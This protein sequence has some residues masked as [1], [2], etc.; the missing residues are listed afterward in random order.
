MSRIRKNPELPEAE[1]ASESDKPARLSRRQVLAGGASI[2]V[3]G[4]AGAM[5]ARAQYTG[6]MEDGL[7]V[8]F[9]LP[10]GALNYLDRNQYINNMEIISYVEGPQISSGEP[11]MTMWARGSRRLIASSN[12]WLDITNP[13][14]PEIMDLG[15]R[16]QGNIV[17]GRSISTF[18]LDHAFIRFDRTA[19]VA[20][21]RHGVATVVVCR[22]ELL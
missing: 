2:A 7:G 22:C 19:D 8:P 11:L 14:K 10:M 18:D 9:R 21:I 16:M 13:R 4:L 5:G 17:I 20:E 12:G 1:N 15:L 6:V 3:A